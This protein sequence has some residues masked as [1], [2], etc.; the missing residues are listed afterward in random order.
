MIAEILQVISGFGRGL[1]PSLLAITGLSLIEFVIPLRSRTGLQNA[2]LGP[3]LSLTFIAFLTNFAFNTA[4]LL[5]L[6]GLQSRGFGLLPK[7]SL[8]PLAALGL[9]IITLDFTTYL[10]HVS[11]HKFSSLWR[12]HSVHH[13]D[14]ALDVTTTARQHPGESVIRY[15]FMATTAIALGATPAMFVTYRLTASLIGFTI[16]SNIGLPVWL[17]TALSWLVTSPNMHKVHHSRSRELTDTNY[18][19]ILTLWDR[20][21]GTFVPSQLG[22]AID[23]GLDGFDEPASQSIGGLLTRPLRKNSSPPALLPVSESSGAAS[24]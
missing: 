13:S 21:F 4:M 17:D 1:V 2:H 15:V 18:G 5:V 20:L 9:A 3:N 8:G 10:A 19:N 22:T 16:H 11:M 7:L 14:L 24:G 12:F 23:Y 6:A